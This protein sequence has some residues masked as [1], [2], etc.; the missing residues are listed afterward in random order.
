MPPFLQAFFAYLGQGGLLTLEQLLLVLGPLLAIAL[1]LQQL[2]A[3]VRNRSAAV[4]IPM[5]SDNPKAKRVEF[6]SPDP[7]ANPYLAFS[8][9]LMAGLDGIQKKIEPP[10]PLNVDIYELEGAEKEKIEQVPGSLQE[11]LNAL[12]KDHAYLLKGGV[13]TEDV[14]EAWIE[15]TWKR[16]VEPVALR[17]H[18][19][20]FYLYHDA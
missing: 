13:F 19:W 8:A 1:L 20:E 3:Y 14:I 7:T 12:K 5:Y 17:P 4:R 11:A 9:L 15:Y 18:P 6:R 10:E 16:E 2:S